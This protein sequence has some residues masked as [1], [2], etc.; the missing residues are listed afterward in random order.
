MN[1]DFY[2][3]D[4]INSY[5]INSYKFVIKFPKFPKI[6]IKIKSCFVLYIYF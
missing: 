6:K 3:S 4:D 5:N 1:Y 2:Y